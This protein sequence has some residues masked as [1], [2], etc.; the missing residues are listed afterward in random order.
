MEAFIDGSS[1]LRR[2][3][4]IGLIN[5]ARRMSGAG[6]VLCDT[7]CLWLERARQRQQMQRLSDQML[8]DIGVSR[9]DVF[10]EC[11][12]PFWKA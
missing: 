4:P 1:A 2:I 12:K 10:R 7:V 9:A 5:A 3:F 6:L 8:N 11:D